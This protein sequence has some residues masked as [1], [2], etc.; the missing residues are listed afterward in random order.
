MGR[1]STRTLVSSVIAAALVLLC[2]GGAGAQAVK[3]GLVGNIVDASGSALPG[4]TV[5]ITEVNTNIAYTTVT[6]ESGN[7]VFANLKDGI[8]RVSGELS[9]FKKTVRDGVIVPV[10]ATLRVDLKLEI[11]AIEESINVVGESPLLQTDRADTSRI[12]ES[13]QLTEQPLGFNRNFQGMMVTVPGA[14]RM[15]RP[16]SDFFNAQDSLSSNVNGQSRLANNVQ[17]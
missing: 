16:H 14:L 1:L 10:N 8:Y 6:N 3:G 15:Q 7:Y 12:I 2:A 17:I 9:G 5:T 11:G 4:V 13:L